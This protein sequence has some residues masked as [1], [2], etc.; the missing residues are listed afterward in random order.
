MKKITIAID[1]YAAC[2][3]STL[4]KK[5][6]K[7]LGWIY[8]DSGAMYRAVT[9]YFLRKNVDLKNKED[10][11][12]TLN[13]FFISFDNVGRTILNGE[14]VESEIRDS[15]VSNFVSQVSAISEVRKKLVDLQRE[16]GKEGGIVMDGRDIGT[17]VF[18][19]AELKLFISADLEI[20]V[21]RRF[22]ELNGK[23]TREEVRENLSERD[24]IDSTR[25]D[26]PLKKA[27]DAIE[28]DN[29]YLNPEEQLDKVLELVMVTE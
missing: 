21:E 12:T 19:N 15:K 20:R 4:A 1:G 24:W 23:I 9:L 25:S 5:I 26:S 3:K 28:I 13:E 16:I 10:I 7:K 14:I 22:K 17:V 11:E 29:S 2:G 27:D 18:P 6:A 8:V